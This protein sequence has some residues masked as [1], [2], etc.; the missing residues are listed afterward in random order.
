MPFYR[1]RLV[2][3]WAH[4][5][6]PEGSHGGCRNRSLGFEGSVPPSMGSH[7]RDTRMGLGYDLQRCAD[8]FEGFGPWP[9]LCSSSVIP[10]SVIL[11]RLFEPALQVSLRNLWKVSGHSLGIYC[12]GRL[13]IL[14]IVLGSGET[15]SAP[16]ENRLAIFCS[17]S[18]RGW[19]RR[20]LCPTE[21][22]LRPWSAGGRAPLALEGTALT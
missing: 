18:A 6:I 17:G 4:L 2:A 12:L 15:E 20:N 9:L 14:V 8:P 10:H 21:T 7:S 5:K 11:R 1:G 13:S 22:A 19:A 16:D 3:L